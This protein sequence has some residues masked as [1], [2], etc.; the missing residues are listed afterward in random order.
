MDLRE[1][2]N[3]NG[4]VINKRVNGMLY[5]VVIDM[6]VSR[7]MMNSWL[8]KHFNEIRQE[9]HQQLQLLTATDQAPPYPR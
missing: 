1:P 6:G 8:A 2:S 7:T 4:F 9:P 5:Q 3:D